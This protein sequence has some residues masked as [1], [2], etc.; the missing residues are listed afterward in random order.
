VKAPA[1]L[2]AALVLGASIV[3][4][5]VPAQSSGEVGTDYVRVGPNG[6]Y[7]EFRGEPF[8][9]VGFNDAVSWGN[10]LWLRGPSAFITEEYFA[11]LAE[12]GLN[13]LRI[14]M[15]YSQDA[16]GEYELEGPLGTYRPDAVA[17]WDRIFELAETHGIMLLL[18]P[19]DP[20][21]MERTWAANPWNAANGGP[22]AA[23]SCLLTSS[24]ARA[25]QR[26]T[27]AFL[28]DRYGGSANILAW[29]LMNEI[30][31]WFRSGGDFE[32]ARDIASWIDEMAGFVS[33]REIA[34]HGRR[35]LITVSFAAATPAGP[36]ADALYDA[37]GLDFV[38]T[39]MYYPPVSRGGD[40]VEAAAVVADGIAFQWYRTPKP[41]LDTESGPIERWPLSLEEDIPTFRAVTWSSLVGG[42]LGP[43][44][45]WP[46]TE[47]GVLH[48]A[49]YEML[50]GAGRF[51][52]SGIPWSTE[53]W[54]Q[55]HRANPARP[56][57]QAVISG[58]VG[59]R[60]AVL[61]VISHEPILAEEWVVHGLADGRY[62][63][64]WWNPARGE[65]RELAQADSLGGQL[66]L[67]V[68]GGSR[69]LALSLK[70]R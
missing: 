39:H 57:D 9:P 52:A 3:W 18:T 30:D 11:R 64:E 13:T 43:G 63:L 68:P 8:I 33:A 22:C 29:E 5:Q 26:A 42:A 46:Y 45:R 17:Q 69:E 34:A 70:P 19:W 2:L 47:T 31:L 48:E 7:L 23:M 38:T 56:S 58:L 27:F 24:E 15:S 65:R 6:R 60:H 1:R 44:M 55:A 41:Y 37:Q 32:Y 16:S 49:H 21:W 25:A 35:H 66:R 62:L 54:E 40:P 50:A 51:A 67:R 36:L 20:F 10:L 12:H 4:I 59:R 14:M 28:I 53:T 61:Y